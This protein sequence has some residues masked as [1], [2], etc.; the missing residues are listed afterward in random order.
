MQ[1][2]M[3]QCLIHL[4]IVRC[5]I[6]P[7]V[8]VRH[9]CVIYHTFYD[10]RYRHKLRHNKARRVR[11]CQSLYRGVSYEIMD[12]VFLETLL[13]QFSAIR[14]KQRQ[15]FRCVISYSN[16][17]S[18]SRNGASQKWLRGLLLW[19]LCPSYLRRRGVSWYME[20]RH[21]SD[22]WRT[23]PRG[24]W[25]ASYNWQVYNYKRTCMYVCMI[26][27]QD[28]IMSQYKV[29]TL[30]YTHKSLPNLRSSHLYDFSFFLLPLHSLFSSFPQKN[31]RGMVNIIRLSTLQMRLMRVSSKV[32]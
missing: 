26:L 12:W 17:S 5:T 27:W 25:G 15:C 19:A 32:R 31:T 28:M 24:S 9:R 7:P 23:I 20:I 18:E 16:G 1:P 8:K 4:S 11:Q 3:N 14:F 10:A 29:Q 30:I 6:R 22:K 2:K 21:T 13:W